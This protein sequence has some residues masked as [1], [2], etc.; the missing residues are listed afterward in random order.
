MLP[1][2]PINLPSTFLKVSSAMSSMLVCPTGGA[3]PLAGQS[4]TGRAGEA[5][6]VEV[7]VGVETVMMCLTSSA[8]GSGP[9]AEGSALL[10]M[11]PP[12]APGPEAREE[13]GT[14][15]LAAT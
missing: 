5:A 14:K 13:E 9:G 6:L 4:P 1:S 10:A 7:D 3:V 8:V 11:L 2:L 15:L 12:T